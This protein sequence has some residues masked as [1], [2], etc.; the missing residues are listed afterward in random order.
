MER[1]DVNFKSEWKVSIKKEMHTKEDGW[2]VGR[3]IDRQY[4]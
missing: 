1:I 4:Q 3:R 2:W